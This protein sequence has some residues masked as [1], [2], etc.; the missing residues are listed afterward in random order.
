MHISVIYNRKHILQSVEKLIL[1]DRKRIP[2]ICNADDAMSIDGRCN[3]IF[4]GENGTENE[5][6]KFLHKKQ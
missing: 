3:R 1:H 5:P 2:I 6:V 4:H